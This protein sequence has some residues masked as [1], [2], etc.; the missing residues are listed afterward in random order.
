MATLV[1]SVLSVSHEYVNV[2][3]TLR[4]RLLPGAL[5]HKL[6][7]PPNTLLVANLKR[8]LMIFLK[9]LLLSDLWV[10]NM[11]RNLSYTGLNNSET[12][13][14]RKRS[15]IKTFLDMY[16][17]V[18][19][20]NSTKEQ[21]LTACKVTLKLKNMVSLS[22]GEGSQGQFSEQG[23][24]PFRLLYQACLQNHPPAK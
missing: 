8:K 23:V 9:L 11:R 12:T 6:L 24:N 10:T 22:S 21:H 2:P 14:K 17:L 15:T 20:R 3:L 7:H 4:C 1:V 13:G 5:D 19:H 18:V 16:N